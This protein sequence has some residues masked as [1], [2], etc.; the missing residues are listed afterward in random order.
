MTAASSSLHTALFGRVWYE[1]VKIV[2]PSSWPSSVCGVN[3]DLDQFHTPAAGAQVMVTNGDIY[4]GYY[5]HT[6]QTGGCGDPG[7][8][9]MIPHMWLTTNNITTREARQFVHLWSR[10]RYGVFAETGF[11]SDPLYPSYYRKDGD[12]VPTLT[13]NAELGGGWVSSSGEECDPSMES[14]ECVFVPEVS[15]GVTCSLGSGLVTT[16]RYCNT[17]ENRVTPTQQSVECGGRSALE[18]IMSHPDLQRSPVSS[19]VNS[20]PVVSVVR[21]ARTR[22]VLA[23]DTSV[24]PDT[25]TWVS[26]AA[27]KLIRHD[28]SLHSHLALLTFNSRVKV[29]HGMVQVDSDSV[30]TTLADTI[31]GRYHLSSGDTGA[32]ISCVLSTIIDNVLGGDTAGAH[33][34]IISSP[35]L[36]QLQQQRSVSDSLARAPLRVSS[37]IIPTRDSDVSR[38]FASVQF[39]DQLS[40]E[41]H[42]HSFKL[43]ETG[44]GIDLLVGVN[45]AFAEILRLSGDV[46]EEDLEE[47]VSLREHYSNSDDNES[48]GDFIIDETLGRDTIFGIY[49]QDEEDHLIKSVTFWDADNHKYGPYTKMSSALDP[50]NIKTINYVGE[51][52]PFGNVS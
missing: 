4:H 15:S 13:H 36:P 31:P 41:T 1:T 3:N 33:V 32:C 20:A 38:D 42:G 46:P 22:Y 5:P 2:I 35:H 47:T 34:I 16:E 18:V 24:S 11:S 29:E 45:Q 19:G 6:V 8:M 28:L 52:P 7:D 23:L 37:I 43:A 25:W 30:R 39:F 50:F 9:I 14:E 49:V 21:M 10:Y 12:I 17:S 44:Y 27:H 48:S 26:K 51:E 40:A